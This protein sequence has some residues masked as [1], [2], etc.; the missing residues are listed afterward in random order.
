MTYPVLYLRVKAMCIDS[1]VLIVLFYSL[2]A[3]IGS[4]DISNTLLKIAIVL[5]PILLIEPLMIWTTGGSI[6]HHFAGI[7]VIDKASG[8]NL[9]VLKGL[10]RFVVKIALGIYSMVTM[11]ITRQHQSLHDLASASVVVFKNESTAP[12]RYKLAPRPTDYPTKK[13]GV[14]R[15]LLVILIHVF[16][17]T[18]GYGLLSPFLA[19][20]KC[21]NENLCSPSEEQT[22]IISSLIFISLLLLVLVLGLCC[23]LPGVRVQK[24]ED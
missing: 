12:E 17:I 5:C 19:S 16:I 11:L 18:I 10:V 15:R 7:R 14:L 13:P 8:G 9:F 22:L 1:I 20:G 24:T 21:L 6:G 3:A 23:K 2:L 4:T